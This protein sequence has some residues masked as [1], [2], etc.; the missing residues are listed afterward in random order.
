MRVTKLL[1]T[2]GLISSTLFAFANGTFDQPNI[3]EEIKELLAKTRIS[4]EESHT[5][6]VNFIINAE[7]ELVVT[8]VSDKEL[9]SKIKSALNYKK[10]KAEVTPYQLYTQPVTITKS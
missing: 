1:M 3:S 6:V 4:V 9:E 8:S 7:H 2:L 5:I 10:V